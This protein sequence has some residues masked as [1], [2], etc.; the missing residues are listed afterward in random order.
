M[1]MAAPV[2]RGWPLRSVAGRSG[3]EL[4]PASI[5]GEPAWRWKSPEPAKRGS[6]EML[7]LVPATVPQLA[8][9]P[10]PSVVANASLW[11]NTGVAVENVWSQYTAPSPAPP[12]MT[13]LNRRDVAKKPPAHTAEPCVPELPAIVLFTSSGPSVPDGGENEMPPPVE[14]ERLPT[15]RFCT[16]TASDWLTLQM[17][18]PSD[19]DELPLITLSAMVGEPAAN[20]TSAPPQVPWLPVIVLPITWAAAAPPTKMPPPR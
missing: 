6:A 13:L 17:A 5:A 1:S 11:S 2:T 12:T 15:I 14:P 10:P 16:I 9:K 20:R 8:S 19:V 3:A 7:P 18:P 4:L